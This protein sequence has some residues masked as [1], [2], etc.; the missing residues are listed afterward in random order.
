MFSQRCDRRRKQR[1]GWRSSNDFAAQ[2]YLQK[3]PD[4]KYAY[5]LKSREDTFLIEKYY[6]S[7]CLS[8]SH[9]LEDEKA[10]LGEYRYDATMRLAFILQYN[11]GK[12]S[13]HCLGGF[14]K[15]P[16]KALEED[17]TLN[18]KSISCCE[19]PF[20]TAI[21]PAL[22]KEVNIQMEKAMLLLYEVMLFDTLNLDGV[23]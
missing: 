21:D 1:L 11:E 6:P 23:D 2:S 12:M 8:F 15:L 10:S 4:K 22:F 16:S 7:D 18:E 13:Y 19:P 14:W 17:G 3:H 9:P 5:W 20:Y